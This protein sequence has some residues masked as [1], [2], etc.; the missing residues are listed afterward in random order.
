L[1][2][3]VPFYRQMAI[4]DIIVLDP[5]TGVVKHWREGEANERT[6]QSP[7]AI[8]LVCGCSATV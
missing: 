3:G 2:I 7:V 1:E 4:R 8:T 6:L 5:E